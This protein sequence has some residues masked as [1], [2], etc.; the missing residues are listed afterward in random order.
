MCTA[1]DLRGSTAASVHT[2]GVRQEL[3]AHADIASS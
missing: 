1:M 2:D 3:S